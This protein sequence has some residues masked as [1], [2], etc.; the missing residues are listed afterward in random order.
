MFFH[1]FRVLH[2]LFFC[3]AR[4]VSDR[5]RVLRESV[6]M[7]EQGGFRAG[8]GCVVFAVR[9]VIE[10]TEEDKVAY[11]AC[12]YLEKAYD[13]VGRNTLWEVLLCER[14]AA[15]SISEAT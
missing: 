10:V 5:L 7:D 11:A 1:A 8:R 15:S 14:K 3:Y 13:S 4:I 2:P 9:H 12:L 6:I